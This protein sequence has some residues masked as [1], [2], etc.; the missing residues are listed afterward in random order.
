MFSTNFTHKIR[1]LR[2]WHRVAGKYRLEITLWGKLWLVKDRQQERSIT[3]FV[4]LQLNV[5]YS[6]SKDLPCGQTPISGE[7]VSISARSHP[8]FVFPLLLHPSFFHHHIKLH[9][10][11]KSWH[12]SNYSDLISVGKTDYNTLLS[13]DII[14]PSKR[15]GYY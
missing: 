4:A 7:A 1:L 3:S 11:G 13:Q 8:S 12:I 15:S 5:S 6:L 14:S 9:L 2:K 10:S